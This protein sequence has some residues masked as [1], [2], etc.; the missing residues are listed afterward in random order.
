MNITVEVV[1]VSSKGQIVLPADIRNKLDIKAG[2]R[3]AAFASDDCV[4]LKI[5]KLPSIEDFKKELNK[6]NDWAE[7]VGYV[8]GDVNKIIKDVRK[9]KRS[10]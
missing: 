9:Q 7:E 4:M 2:D 10:L 3:L 6:L 1:T 8:E 5:I